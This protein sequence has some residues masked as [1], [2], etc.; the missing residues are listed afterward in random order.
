MG[1]L[2]IPSTPTKYRQPSTKLPCPILAPSKSCQ[3]LG[4]RYG[5]PHGPRNP[6]PADLAEVLTSRNGPE[7]KLKLQ[8]WSGL[9]T[10]SGS[11]CPKLRMVRN[12][13][14]SED[15][16]TLANLSEN[17]SSTTL[18]NGGCV[19]APFYRGWQLLVPLSVQVT[20]RFHPSNDQ[21]LLASRP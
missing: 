3:H 7:I 17:Q 2:V 13:S 18:Y 15:R 5:K 14:T 21:C 11:I 6:K 10:V 16:D 8:I 19:L 4:T 20:R 12:L 9:R 1:S